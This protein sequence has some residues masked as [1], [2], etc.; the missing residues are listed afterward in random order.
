METAWRE[1]GKEKSEREIRVKDEEKLDQTH[2]KIRGSKAI[3]H[4]VRG[5]ERNRHTH[6]ERERK[7]ERMEGEQ[8]EGKTLQASLASDE[9]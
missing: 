1:S 8:E 2:M 6:R 4:R 3:T 5:C 9:G 7:K